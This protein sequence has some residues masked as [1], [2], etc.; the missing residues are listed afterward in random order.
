MGIRKE[1]VSSFD[2]KKKIN[3][4][5]EYDFQMSHRH[6]YEVQGNYEVCKICGKKIL[7]SVNGE[8][9]RKDGKKYYI[10]DNRMSWLRP[11]QAQGVR[12]RL[13][14]QK[15]KNTFDILLNLGCRINEGRHIE[16]YDVDENLKQVTLRVTKTKAR[17]GERKGKPRTLPVST[18]FI[19]RIKKMFDKNGKLQYLSTS[20]F[21]IALKKAIKKYAKDTGDNI[22]YKMFSAHN[23]RKTHGNWLRMLR[24]VGMMN[25]SESGICVRMGHDMDTYIRDYASSGQLSPEEMVLAKQMLG[26][27]YGGQRWN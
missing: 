17:K 10:R 6:E 18:Q 21:N 22:D 14:S 7:H 9:V 2:V 8:A 3:Y 23:I 27:L 16:P 11:K 24:E 15:A 19:K 1:K 13:N 25:I 12:E 20:A 4:E 5:D 26:D